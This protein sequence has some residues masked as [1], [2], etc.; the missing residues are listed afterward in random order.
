MRTI[1]YTWEIGKLAYSMVWECTPLQMEIFIKGFSIMALAP[2]VF[3][4][5]LMVISMKGSL[6]MDSSM[7][8]GS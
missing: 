3:S 4:I 8:T 2:K 1:K 5:M 7:V 6:R